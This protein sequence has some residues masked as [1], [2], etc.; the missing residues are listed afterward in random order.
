[1]RILFKQ[2]GFWLPCQHTD[3]KP[4]LDMAV[5]IA[6]VDKKKMLFFLLTLQTQI[7]DVHYNR[8]WGAYDV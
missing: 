1:M 5:D 6:L 3:H 2:E 7:L 4:T 8:L